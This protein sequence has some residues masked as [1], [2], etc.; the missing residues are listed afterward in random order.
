MKTKVIKAKKDVSKKVPKVSK[1]KQ[2]AVSEPKEKK[3]KVKLVSYSVTAII[4]TG[5]YSNIQTSVTVEAETM[6]IAERAVMPHIERM[7]AK[8]RDTNG[9]ARTVVDEPVQ[10]PGQATLPI[11]P[12]VIPTTPTVQPVAVTSGANMPVAPIVTPT[13]TQPNTVLANVFDKASKA[14]SSCT[15]MDALTLVR[16]QIS[17]SEK[18]SDGEKSNLMSLCAEKE[19]QLMG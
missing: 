12:V 13:P 9:Q 14:V 2:K 8:Y 1:K 17:I 6:E 7:F 18:L 4:P 19:F 15:S 3:P 11:V 10:F 5:N 16:K